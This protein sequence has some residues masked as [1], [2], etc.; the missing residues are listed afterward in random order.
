MTTNVVLTSTR[1]PGGTSHWSLDQD[2]ALCALKR[3]KNSRYGYNNED[4][5]S[6]YLTDRTPKAIKLHYTDLLSLS[7]RWPKSQQEQFLHIYNTLLQTSLPINKSILELTK[8][9][10]YREREAIWKPC[11]NG[12]GM[13][14]DD[15]ERTHKE[16]CRKWRDLKESRDALWFNL[17]VPEEKLAWDVWKKYDK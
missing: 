16:V 12:L 3:P 4:I 5:S 11:A 7:R 6:R 14:V 8:L 17:E 15:V 1:K 10:G 13:S 2:I 9:L